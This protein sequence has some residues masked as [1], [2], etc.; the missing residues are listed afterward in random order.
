MSG[1][2]ESRPRARPPVLQRVLLLATATRSPSPPASTRPR[3]VATSEPCLA[4]PP[5]PGPRPR[6][7]RVA[8]RLAATTPARPRPAEQTN[9]QPAERA[10]RPKVAPTTTPG[11]RTVREPPP[12]RPLI[13][14][15]RVE[16]VRRKAPPVPGEP[17]QAT[18]RESGPVPVPRQEPVREP[19]PERV[20]KLVPQRPAREGAGQADRR[21][22][23]DRR[24]P[25]RRGARAAQT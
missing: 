11:V 3:P 6:R 15:R 14:G 20:P 10:S 16:P 12:R 7:G 2:S 24:R 19:E 23:R 9:A 5:S 4:R 22:R 8:A 1:L 13:A 18:V 21:S 17:R 25:G